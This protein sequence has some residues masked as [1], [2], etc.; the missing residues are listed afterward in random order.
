MALGQ[1]SLCGFLLA[2]WGC[3]REPIAIP[4]SFSTSP[5]APED[6]ASREGPLHSACRLR[7]AKHQ[8]D[9]PAQKPHNE[10]CEKSLS[11]F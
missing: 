9:S 7:Q 1:G 8:V 10:I 11:A 6:G 4:L 2:P 3:F 5:Q